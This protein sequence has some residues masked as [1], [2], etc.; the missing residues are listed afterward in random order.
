[1]RRMAVLSILLCACAAAQV[2]YSK[3]ISRIFQ[4]RCNNC[5]RPNDIT[6]FALEDYNSA[7]T[8]ARDI[9]NSLEA[10]S[11]P[12][13]KPVPGYG[14]FVDARTMPDSEKQMVYDWVSNGMPE[15]DPADLPPAQPD[16]G[17]WPLGQP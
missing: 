10:G 15:G 6:P 3:D 13:W 8:W 4:A 7:V 14:D 2:T 11:M 5:H 9:V 16:P 12:P 1:M 17:P